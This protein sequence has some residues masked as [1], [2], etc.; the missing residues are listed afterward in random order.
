MENLTVLRKLFILI[1]SL[2]Q[3]LITKMISSL[4]FLKNI[5]KMGRLNLKQIINLGEN[6][7]LT[8]NGLKINNLNLEVTMPEIKKLMSGFTI[9][10][11][12]KS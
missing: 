7:E 6:T 12:A 2:N 11:Q 4:T 1:A 10:I 5:M 9:R 3:K 8:K